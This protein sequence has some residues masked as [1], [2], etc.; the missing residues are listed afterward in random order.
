MNEESLKKALKNAYQV[1]TPRQ[2]F[3]MPAATQTRPRILRIALS[4]MVAAAAFIA[5][6]GFYPPFRAN[7][8]CREVAD[9]LKSQRGYQITL[10]VSTTP[11]LLGSYNQPAYFT[12]RG[13]QMTD[14][15]PGANLKFDI[16]TNQSIRQ[17]DPATRTYQT[18]PGQSMN[19]VLPLLSSLS[20]VDLSKR[21]VH[22][23]LV[24]ANRREV[25]RTIVRMD[26]DK[27]PTSWFSAEE[28]RVDLDPQTDLPIEVVLGGPD[29]ED[30]STTSQHFVFDYDSSKVDAA[31]AGA[32]TTGYRE[33][34]FAKMS[35]SHFRPLGSK[36]LG[37]DLLTIYKVEENLAGDVF[38]LYTLDGYHK[39]A[40]RRAGYLYLKDDAG[41]DWLQTV[42]SVDHKL[43]VNG[44]NPK[45]QI[46]FPP[47]GPHV[48]S[49]VALYVKLLDGWEFQ[50]NGFMGALAPDGYRLIKLPPLG[51]KVTP[52][53]NIHPT[54]VEGCPDWVLANSFR[55]SLPEIDDRGNYLR[56]EV[57]AARGDY[58][59]SSRLANELLDHWRFTDMG[60]AGQKGVVAAIRFFS[61]WKL[62]NMQRLAE[63]RPALEEAV[64]KKDFFVIDDDTHIATKWL[65]QCQP[66]SRPPASRSKMRY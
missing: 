57:A 34:D 61:D 40:K 35:A 10:T 59:G 5:I 52:V 42:I 13:N 44:M 66:S 7:L 22:I 25:D 26:K 39:D 53:M 54:P 36:K 12:F 31:F 64:R 17:Y 15:H 37:R 9:R 18:F 63:D 38:V 29:T 32:D 23:G 50:L 30:S 8:F 14:W 24:K 2:A 33:V 6:V 43:K 65:A 28:I 45:A 1:E 3:E 60:F 41:K 46:F 62:G 11:E 51:G 4:A 55:A 27:K 16:A 49:S 47:V 19:P 56:M 21:M 20:K 48:A 58:L